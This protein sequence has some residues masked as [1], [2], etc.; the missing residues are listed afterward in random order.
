MCKNIIAEH[1]QLGTGLLIQFEYLAKIQIVAVTH[2]QKNNDSACIQMFM[3]ALV[4]TRKAFEILRT[5]SKI[6]FSKGI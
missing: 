4:K 6:E 3:G 2:P 1:T 5:L